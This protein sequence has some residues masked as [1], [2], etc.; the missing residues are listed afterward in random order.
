MNSHLH[1][2][3]HRRGFTL[4]ELL[5]VVSIIAIL[6][7]LTFSVM[8]GLTEQAEVE[9]TVVTVRKV[10][11]V[12]QQR[13]EGFQRAFKGDRLDAASNIVRA[14]LSENQIFGVRDEVIEVL[15]KKRAF[16]YEFP[17]RMVERYVEEHPSG[18]GEKVTGMADSIFKSIAAPYAIQ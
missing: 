9:A 3:S 17:Q 2:T 7:G 10:D 11:A 16:R 4:L 8:F 14:K 5:I 1:H 18:S 6:M 15:A 13:V 12:L